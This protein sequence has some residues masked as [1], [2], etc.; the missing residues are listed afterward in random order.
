MT[1]KYLM[2]G[3]KL[4]WHLD[5]VAAWQAGER[6]APLHIDVGLSKGCNI[7]CHYCF[8]A[9]QGNLYRKGSE[10]FFPRAPLLAYMRDAGRAGVRSMALVGESEPTL[11]P[12]LYEAVV[13]GRRAGVDMA[14]GTNG[15]LWDTGA[16]GGA[17]LEH[18]TWLRFNLSAASDES[19][20]RLHGSREF[21]AVLNA[22][23]HVVGTKRRR[24]LPVTVGLQM[25]LTPLNVGEVVPLARLGAELGV[26]YLVV[27]QCSD[28]VE[29]A[30]GIFR[31]LGEYA[32]YTE[33]LRAA[34]ALS[35]PGYDVIVKWRP[36]EDKGVRSY[37]TCL[38]A[39]FLLYSSGD[40]RLYP[41]GMFFE[42]R[43]EEFRMGDLTRQSFT[44]ILAS[45]RYW[46]VVEK[47]RRIDVSGCYANCK[48]HSI[49][50]FLWQ[51]THPPEHVNFI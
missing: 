14:V 6:I 47:V 29:N 31:R 50:E 1:D 17:A 35:A 42:Q 38:G 2:S 49:N 23:R 40:G 5:R 4:L 10:V 18:L 43:E 37:T 12:H 28:T 51:L 44:E 32:D 8:G 30:L 11:N 26:D 45:E 46:E 16:A 24:G 33:T 36:I 41:C 7:R 25:V 20:R 15:V 22:V 34:E 3:H 19:Y 27:K 48:T 9:L 39:P 21:A 13:E